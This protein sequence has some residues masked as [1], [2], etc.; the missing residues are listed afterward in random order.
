MITPESNGYGETQRQASKEAV[1]LVHPLLWPKAAV[2]KFMHRQEKRVIDR[3]ANAVRHQ[4]DCCPRGVTLV[5]V[6]VHCKL[7]HYGQSTEYAFPNVMTVEFLNLRVF[8]QYQSS[9][10]GMA[11]WS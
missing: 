4:Q 11:Y 9:P 7:N 3:R 1:P 6:V 2:A 5:D 10:E 8:F